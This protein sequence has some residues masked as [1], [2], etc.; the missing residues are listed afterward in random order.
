MKR[1]QT[2][3]R[4]KVTYSR[5]FSHWNTLLR[6]HIGLEYV[7]PYIKWW[8]VYLN[9]ARRYDTDLADDWKGNADGILIFTGLFSATVA[10]FIVEGY[11]SLQPDSAADSAQLLGQIS[12]QLAALSNGTHLPPPTIPQPSSFQPSIA[13]I[14]F[15]VCWFLSLTFSLSCA[16]AATLMQRWARKY[17]RSTHYSHPNSQIRA[18]IRTYKFEGARRFGM[19]TAMETIVAVLHLSVLV[20][21]IGLIQFLFTINDTVALVIMACVAVGGAAYVVLTALP[22][23]FHDCPY[24]TPL[25]A[26]VTLLLRAI[27]IIA[28]PIAAVLSPMCSCFCTFH[29]WLEF[30]TR[31]MESIEHRP[32]SEI[33]MSP[34]RKLNLQCAALGWTLRSLT[35]TDQFEAFL[36]DVPQLLCSTN[37]GNDAKLIMTYLLRIRR[38]RLGRRITSLLYSCTTP[39]SATLADSVR[40]SRAVVCMRAMWYLMKYLD[41][42]ALTAPD[43]LVTQHLFTLFGE[44]IGVILN[45]MKTDAASSVA[46]AAR[47]TAALTVHAWRPISKGYD[48]T[49]SSYTSWDSS[50]VSCRIFLPCQTRSCRW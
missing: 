50:R 30:T 33:V 36:A 45:A 3:K 10:A 44:R 22:F 27:S 11:K 38:L 7:D 9:K 8:A 31:V 29:R 48:R 18:Q 28:K 16:L 17:L 14:R 6:A 12:Q 21:W 35:D 46:V 5:T 23:F 37:A 26:P 49:F 34:T 42:T 15:N 2:T 25:Q 32:L 20:F 40:Q 1:V 39:D 43:Y 47:C 4:T 13:A 41:L 19:L 24:S